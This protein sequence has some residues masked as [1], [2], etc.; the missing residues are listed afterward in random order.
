MKRNLAFLKFRN[1]AIAE[2]LWFH[3][4]KGSFLEL[5]ETPVKKN[6]PFVLLL[7]QE[8]QINTMKTDSVALPLLL[9]KSNLNFASKSY[10]LPSCSVLC[11][12]TQSCLT[13]WDPLDCSLPGSSVHG[14]FQAR[15]LEWVAISSS[16]GSS[17]TRDQ[18]CVSCNADRFFTHWDIR[19][20]LKFWNVTYWQ[21]KRKKVYKRDGQHNELLWSLYTVTPEV[22]KQN[23]PASQK[24][25]DTL[26]WLWFSSSL[27]VTP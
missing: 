16:R 24:S 7:P 10:V 21:K 2:H 5:L 3:Q 12:V 17:W 26:S 15:I 20:L 4:A 9:A 8:I 27:E 1:S 25:S 13:L 6:W 18:T 19:Y 22:R 14:I 11:L 23:L